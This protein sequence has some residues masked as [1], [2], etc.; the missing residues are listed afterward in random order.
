MLTQPAGKLGALGCRAPQ[1]LASDC[2]QCPRPPTLIRNLAGPSSDPDPGGQ[3]LGRK[4]VRP[5]APISN[6][7]IWCSR[8]LRDLGWR[9][10]SLYWSPERDRP[11]PGV[12]QH[13][14]S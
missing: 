3:L 6:T 5:L 11:S 10:L 2:Q 9:T 4:V 13:G 8:G 12:T 14:N 7:S 1:R